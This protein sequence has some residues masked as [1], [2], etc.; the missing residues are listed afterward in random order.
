[1]DITIIVAGILGNSLV[2]A[3]F[4]SNYKNATNKLIFHQSVIDL[5]GVIIFLVARVIA[6]PQFTEIP[7]GHVARQVFCR[8]WY[9]DFCMWSVYYTSTFNLVLI[10]LERYAA[11]CHHIWYRNLR[12]RGIVKF[13]YVLPWIFGFGSQVYITALASYINGWCLVIWPTT[14]G[15]KAG[16]IVIFSIEFLLPI[17]IM[18]WCYAKVII[19]IRKREKANRV[20]VREDNILLLSK[21]VATTM[22]TITVAYMVCWMPS[23]IEYVLFNLGLYDNYGGTSYYI[24]SV[25]T[26]LNLVVNPCIYTYKYKHFQRVLR[27][28]VCPRLLNRNE[29]RDINHLR[30]R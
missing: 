21:N 29:V 5:I 23:E 3:V 9:T 14:S 18:T 22:V 28:R 30:V 20:L 2:C 15:Q 1:M 24:F 26:S 7:T 6:H 8:I 19:V 17:S 16:G 11:S 10:A 4:L 13:A 25:L 12:L 27:R